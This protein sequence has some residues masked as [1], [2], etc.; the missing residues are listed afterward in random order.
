M[1]NTSYPLKASTHVIK[2]M[3]RM[4]LHKTKNDD[5][6][7]Y[8]FLKSGA[9][10]FMYRHKYYDSLDV[11]REKK[12]SSFKTEKEA[13]KELLKVKVAILSGETRHIGNEILTVAQWLDTWF[14]TNKRKWK[15]ATIAQRET[16]IR[17]NI[18][19]F[20][21]H[22][23]L[24]KLDKLTYQVN[25]INVLELKYAPGT[26]RIVHPVFMIA[27]NAAVED[28]ILLR[29]KLRRVS[30]PSSRNTNAELS[31]LTSDQI[32]TMLTYTKKHEDETYYT[33][34]LLLSYT[35]MRKG[36]ALG[37][38]WR[39]LN[40]ET[41]TVNIIRNR[42][43]FGTGTTKTK[44][45]ER[46]IKV[47]KNVTDQLHRYRLVVK[48]QMLSEGRKLEDEDYVFL[49]LVS[50]IPMPVTTLQ[51]GFNRIIES[52]GL[53]DSTLHSLRHSH[54]AILMNDRI[55]IILLE[56]L[57]NGWETHQK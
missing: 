39:E 57:P 38:Q 41:Q 2:G 20:I 32:H 45:S 47:G 1:P 49:S 36:E 10:R 19:P 6:V 50:L 28:E 44:N 43:R 52:A 53:K 55:I 34:L 25:L 3:I 17:L 9:K 14:E 35:G 22:F 37:L 48:E 5:E 15:P 12:K 7:N 56:I 21:G 42:T 18:K 23:K 40:F 29:N 27:I 13:L 31:V 30:L 16:M 24:R 8:Y 4:K 51:K 33:I 11:R 46:K 54:A 26:V